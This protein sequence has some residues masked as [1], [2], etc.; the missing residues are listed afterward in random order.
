[1]PTAKIDFDAGAALVLD[2]KMKSPAF[3]LRILEIRAFRQRPALGGFE[4]ETQAD[5]RV[6]RA[7]GARGSCGS[8]V[9][10]TNGNAFKHLG[11]S[12]S[13]TTPGARLSYALVRP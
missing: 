1:M 8:G 5:V 12:V 4:G 9:L 2:A 6:R 10:A 11:L 7:R 13:A 3:D